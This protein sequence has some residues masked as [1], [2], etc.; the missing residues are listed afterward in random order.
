MRQFSHPLYMHYVSSGADN[1][2]PSFVD[3]ELECGTLPSPDLRFS[4]SVDVLFIRLFED[5]AEQ[6]VA[7][8][9]IILDGDFG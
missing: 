2:L 7:G 6:L 4:R 9:Q 3:G 5:T 8:P 1:H